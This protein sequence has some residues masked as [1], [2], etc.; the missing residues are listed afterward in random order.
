MGFAKVPLGIK[1]LFVLL[2]SPFC[3]LLLALVL[4]E[5]KD[6][7]VAYKITN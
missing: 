7:K 3:L 1:V 2:C 5:I 6:E 4:R